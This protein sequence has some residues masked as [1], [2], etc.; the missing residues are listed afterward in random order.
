[1]GK[2]FLGNYVSGW[3]G[4]KVAKMF[5]GDERLGQLAGMASDGEPQGSAPGGEGA[6]SPLLLIT[7]FEKYE[8]DSTLFSFAFTHWAFWLSGVGMIW[9]AVALAIF[10]AVHST[11]YWARSASLLF[12][13]VMLGYGIYRAFLEFGWNPCPKQVVLPIV[14]GVALVAI[15]LTLMG[16]TYFFALRSESA[17][18]RDYYPPASVKHFVG[19]CCPGLVTGVPFGLLSDEG[20]DPGVYAW[21]AVP[22]HEENRR[23]VAAQMEE[24]RIKI[25]AERKANGLPPPKKGP[26]WA[27][28]PPLY[29]A[30]TR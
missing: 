12:V 8:E 27:S 5:G 21:D 18:W 29:S 4:G 14:G 11:I 20:W 15:Y 9:G 16:L 23:Y 2:G 26:W 17:E 25:E 19:F 7:R 30:T 10:V 6:G 13:I 22:R 1:M 3:M 24:E 28:D